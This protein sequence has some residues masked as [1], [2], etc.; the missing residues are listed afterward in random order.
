MFDIIVDV[1]L[2]LIVLVGA[3][4]GFKRG[5]IKMAARPVKFI[6]SLAIAFSLATV[7]A[8]SFVLPMLETPISNYLSDF[9]REN[10]AHITSENAATD[11]PTVIKFSAFILDIDIAE[12]VNEGGNDAVI[13]IVV[14]RLISPVIDIAANIIS[15]I[16]I[17]IVCNILFALLFAIINAIFSSGG[18][19]VFNRILGLVCSAAFALIIAWGLAVIGSFV[20]HS[21]L[22]QDNEAV[23]G[24]VG[25][26]IYNFFNTYNPIQLLLRL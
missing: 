14:D 3:I 25:G 16:V 1:L 13:E 10:Y 12:V 26:P 4:I 6:A 20:I 24:F 15:F 21:S 2:C 5:F 8:Q 9:L 7:V 18:I 11:L 19:G 17:F 23:N 22:F